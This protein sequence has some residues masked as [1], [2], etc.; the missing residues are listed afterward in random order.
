MRIIVDIDNTLWPMAD[1]L[2]ARL[3]EKNPAVPPWQEWH[4]WFFWKRFFSD[5]EFYKTVEEVHLE[6]ENHSPFPDAHFFL[7]SLKALD[8]DIVIASHRNPVTYDLTRRW[9]QIT[10]FLTMTSTSLTIKRFYL[11]TS[12]LWWTTPRL[13]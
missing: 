1:V 13:Y 10:I 7:T 11:T 9:L 12:A 2:C 5:G 4:D 6:Q 3:K 8:F